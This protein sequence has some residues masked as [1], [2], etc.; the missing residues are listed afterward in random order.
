MNVT[1]FSLW[2]TPGQSAPASN[3]PP[4]IDCP[5]SW[6]GGDR[7]L[8]DLARVIL[9][10]LMPTEDRKHFYQVQQTGIVG[11]QV[12]AHC[13]YLCSVRAF[14]GGS[15]DDQFEEDEALAS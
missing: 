10:D 15:D 3:L 12:I 13:V 5:F 1:Q 11:E 2:E 6:A 14:F 7:S 8:E 4:F 9:D